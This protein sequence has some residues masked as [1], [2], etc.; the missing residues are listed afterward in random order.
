MVL[1][2]AIVGLLIAGGAFEARLLSA[3]QGST[4]PAAPI[5]DEQGRTITPISWRVRPT[6]EYPD[7][8][9]RQGVAEGAAVL[10]CKVTSAGTLADCAVVSETPADAGFGQAALNS[11]GAARLRPATVDGVETP[12]RARFTIRFRLQ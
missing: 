6:P 1:A 2:G 3:S 4:A 8:A 5:V 10:S 7:A 9:A 11:M 12:G